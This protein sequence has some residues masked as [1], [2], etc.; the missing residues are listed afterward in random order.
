[1]ALVALSTEHEPNLPCERTCR[2]ERDMA[3][4]HASQEQSRDCRGG[5]QQLEITYWGVEIEARDKKK[6]KI[7]RAAVAGRATGF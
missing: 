7:P 6:V 2:V 4:Q 3:R 1:M 5:F